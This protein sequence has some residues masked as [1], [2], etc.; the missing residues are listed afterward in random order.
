MEG[1]CAGAQAG[2][3]FV[4]RGRRRW[5]LLQCSAGGIVAVERGSPLCVIEE[6]QVRVGA[7]L[8]CDGVEMVTAFG[9]WELEMGITKAYPS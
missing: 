8:G 1:R 6:T 9:P 4:L 7:D 5:L 3:R 2:R